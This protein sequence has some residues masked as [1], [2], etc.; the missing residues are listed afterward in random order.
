MVT[1]VMVD[2][3]TIMLVAVK[4]LYHL[5][6]QLSMAALRLVAICTGHVALWL[7]ILSGAP[8]FKLEGYGRTGNL[9]EGYY[10]MQPAPT[11]VI[12][13]AKVTA[14]SRFCVPVGSQ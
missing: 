14:N 7:K 1:R 9:L 5:R 6:R 2:G 13:F 10:A 3:S 8:G 12:C 4:A 11:V